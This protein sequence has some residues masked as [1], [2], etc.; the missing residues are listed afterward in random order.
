M[1]NIQM[2]DKLFLRLIIKDITVDNIVDEGNIIYD[3]ISR[4]FVQINEKELGLLKYAEELC[5]GHNYPKIE[6]NIQE[7]S[8]AI[9]NL[10]RHN[11][12]SINVTQNALNTGLPD[13][14]PFL[15]SILIKF[16]SELYNTY[17]K[18]GP[19]VASYI[20]YCAK[21]N[22]A[23]IE[24]SSVMP[25]DDESL[26]LNEIFR[27]ETDT[28]QKEEKEKFTEEDQELLKIMYEAVF[29]EKPLKNSNPLFVYRN[30]LP[31]YIPEKYKN[32]D[33]D[34]NVLNDSGSS[35]TNSSTLRF[36]GAVWYRKI[37]ETTVILAGL[38]GIG[39]H[40]AFLIGR[41]RPK[42]LLIYDADFVEEVNMAGQL[43]PRN[44]IGRTKAGAMNSFIN[45]YADG[46]CAESYESNYEI[47]TNNVADIMICGFDKMSARKMYYNK[48]LYHVNQL[49]ESR[50]KE[51][52]FIDGR[53]AAE[54]FQIYA[55]S[56]DDVESMEKYEDKALFSDEEAERTICSYKQTTFMATMIASVM[57]N[58][59]VN[60]CANM[61]NP[62]FERP[63]PF[64]TEY[65]GVTMM[66]KEEG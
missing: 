45:A 32:V 53:L 60:F 17:I 59:F 23:R 25:E 2:L 4:R 43:F 41:M 40:L 3:E 39:S 11:I 37:Q 55:I 5:S 12:K 1:V 48:W 35:V 22:G 9:S 66:M 51:C 20:V 34:S 26:D 42:R 16:D 62:V 63:I 52:L 30:T 31:L 29:T 8:D 46:Y 14:H 57:C 61:C 36:S 6:Y 10:N 38:G 47:D 65:D 56:G 33:S 58:V 28:Q 15:F 50:K 44:M 13:C 27:D 21:L 24:Y 54:M 18:V 19:V 49:P 64:Y 7:V